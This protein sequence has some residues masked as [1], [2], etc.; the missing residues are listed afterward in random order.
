MLILAALAACLLIL[1]LA[2]VPLLCGRIARR[3]WERLTENRP[4]RH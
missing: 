3:T 2:V 1:P 4:S